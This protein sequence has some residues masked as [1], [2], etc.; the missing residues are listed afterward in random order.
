MPVTA[1]TWENLTN[2]TAVGNDLSND[3]GGTD[4]CYTNAS[5]TGDA[6]GSSVETIASSQDWEFRCTLGPNPSGR[7]FVG[8]Q[9]GTF[10]LDFADWQYC[11][12]VST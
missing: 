2:A 4:V 3:N 9:D 12:H 6:G 5:G 11:L 1:I 7:T 8:I 10:S